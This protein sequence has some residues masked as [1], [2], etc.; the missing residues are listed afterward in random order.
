M[1]SNARSLR[2]ARSLGWLIE[3]V[4]RWNPHAKKRHDL[5]GFIDLVAVQPGRGVVAIQACG[6][7]S[8]AEHRRKIQAEPN[9]TKWLADGDVLELWTWRKLKVKRG[10]K[11]VR[12]SVKRQIALLNFVSNVITWNTIPSAATQN[13][14]TG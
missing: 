4:E 8:A 6:G 12:W 2:Y 5:F 7:S 1:T 3:V 13:R 9:A 10:G 14:E 11:A